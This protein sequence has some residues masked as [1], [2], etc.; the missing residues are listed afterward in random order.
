MEYFLQ[1][2]LSGLAN[3]AIYACVALAVVMIYQAIDHFNFAQGEM[4]MFSTF[5]AWQMMQWGMPFWLVFPVCVVISFAGGVVIERVIFGPIHN[6]PVL[7]HVIVFIA[8]FSIF[9]SL[10]GFI[11]EF[12]IKPFPSPFPEK[13]VLG[14]NLIAMHELGMIGITLVMLVMI[15]LF[16]RFTPIGL[17]MRAAAANPVSARLVGISVKW[18]LSLGWGLAAAIGAVAGMLIAP[19]VYLEPNMMLGILL[20]GFAGAVV[21]GLTSPGGAVAGGFLVG[22]AENL[23]GAYVIGSELKL[24]FAL[25][26]IVGVLLLRPAGLFGRVVVNRV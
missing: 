23:A 22:V 5:I 1:Q 9:N 10:A 15:Y 3:G 4:A 12:T 16:F 8:L 2:T 13:D 14:T 19:M 21:G 6:A 24:T 11:W 25:V 7:S 17:A 18:M 26:L 20:Y